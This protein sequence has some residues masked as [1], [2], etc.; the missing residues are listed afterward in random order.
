MTARIAVL[1]SGTGSNLQSLIDH[2]AAS[3][4][5]G[6]VVWVGSNRAE[7]FAL[8]RAHAAGIETGV[9]VDPTDGASLRAQLSAARIDL[10]VLAGYLK[11]VPADVV[12]LFEGRCL[13]IHPSLLPAFGGPSMYGQRVHE[14][15]IAHGARVSGATVHFVDEVFDR[16]AIVAQWPVRVLADDT[17]ALLA[18]RV[19]RAEHRLLPLAVEA[20]ARGR[21]TL[22]PDGRV[23]GDVPLP[24]LPE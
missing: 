23:R 19:L 11:L 24:P 15:V 1:A 8:T 20:V 18:A 13:N 4:D 9:I 6:T 5:A 16:G 22:S 2:F 21:V 10:I 7:A 12:T 14:A 17:P 3:P